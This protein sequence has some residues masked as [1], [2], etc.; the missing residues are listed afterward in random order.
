MDPINAN[1]AIINSGLHGLSALTA[2]ITCSVIL[3]GVRLNKGAKV[4]RAMLIAATGLFVIGAGMA[5]LALSEFGLPNIGW[6]DTTILAGLVL[7][8][9]GAIDWR[10][11]IKQLTK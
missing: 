8:L 5:N 6:T 4:N 10:R 9:L 1:S 11:L 7:V 2:L 3:S